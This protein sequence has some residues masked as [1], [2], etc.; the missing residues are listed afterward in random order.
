[1]TCDQSCCCL[2]VC[3]SCGCRMDGQLSCVL[4]IVTMKM[5]CVSCS[6]QDPDVNARNQARVL[7]DCFV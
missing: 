6:G 1:M 4:L 5:L 7:L 2:S 3:Y